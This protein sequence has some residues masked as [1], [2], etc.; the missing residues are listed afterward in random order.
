MFGAFLA[1]DGFTVSAGRKIPI[2]PDEKSPPSW[3]R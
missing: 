2:S 1:D 3:L